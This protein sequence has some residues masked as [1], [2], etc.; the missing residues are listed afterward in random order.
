MSRLTIIA[1]ITSLDFNNNKVSLIQIFRLNTPECCLPCLSFLHFLPV[2]SNQ[3][4]N[5]INEILTSK[6]RRLFSN[7]F[8]KRKQPYLF[9]KLRMRETRQKTTNFK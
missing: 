1:V 3:T 6:N 7:S 4:L 9:T 8:V 2:K 5:E